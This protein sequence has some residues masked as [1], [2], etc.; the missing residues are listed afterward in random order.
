[1]GESMLEHLP[2][3]ALGS[4]IDGCLVAT[5]ALSAY[6]TAL[7]VSEYGEL[8]AAVLTAEAGEAILILSPTTGPAAPVAGLAA[9]ALI[10]M[11]TV[12]AGL[13]VMARASDMLQGPPV[14]DLSLPSTGNAKLD[15]AARQGAKKVGDALARQAGKTGN[16]MHMKPSLV[17]RLPSRA[18]AD[19]SFKLIDAGCKA[20]VKEKDR[21]N[22]IQP[23]QPR[24]VDE[25]LRFHFVQPRTR[26]D[27]DHIGPTPPPEAPPKPDTQGGGGIHLGD[28]KN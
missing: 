28:S 11:G 25:L 17:G 5:D 19:A 13:W 16:A 18:I 24:T 2:D 15:K 8:T 7:E 1:M 14:P 20:L 6:S 27:L 10:T 3:S 12:D 23:V 22:P 21:R 9:A 4:A 26:S